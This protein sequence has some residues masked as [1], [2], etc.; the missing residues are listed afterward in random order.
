[1]FTIATIVL[2]AAVILATELVTLFTPLVVYL[3]TW[4]LRKVAPK[5]PGWVIVMLI[6][7]LLSLAVAALTGFLG[8]TTLTFWQQFAYGLLAVFVNELYKQ[9]KPETGK[10]R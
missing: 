7:P 8:Q 1:M 2:I 3:V 9:L 5:L 6:V 10:A 4:A